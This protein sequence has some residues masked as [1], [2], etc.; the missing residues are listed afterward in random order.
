MEQ[1]ILSRCL[2]LRTFIV[3]ET[4]YR[5]TNGFYGDSPEVASA[6]EELGELFDKLTNAEKKHFESLNH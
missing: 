3:N 5:D 1:D 6:R 2:E 4:F